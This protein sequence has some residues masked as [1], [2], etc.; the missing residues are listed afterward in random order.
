MYYVHNNQYYHESCDYH[1]HIFF[2]NVPISTLKGI[3]KFG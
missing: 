1:F 3:G 2:F